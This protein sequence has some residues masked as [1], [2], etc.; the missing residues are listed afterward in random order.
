MIRPSRDAGDNSAR[1]DDVD[2]EDD[3][4]DENEEPPHRISIT[5]AASEALRTGLS[6]LPEEDEEIPGQ[7]RVLRAGDPDVDPMD[8]EFSGENVPG[9]GHPSPDQN[10]V[11]DIGRIYGVT[12]TDDG[13]LVLGADLI[14]RRDEHRWELNPASREDKEE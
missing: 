6:E 11:D 13:E 2:P 10:Q 7:D 8:N 4:V 5:A 9:G 12:K 14:N 1:T 3:L